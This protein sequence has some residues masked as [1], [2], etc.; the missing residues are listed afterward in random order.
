MARMVLRK[1]KKK[2]GIV[3]RIF[4]SLVIMGLCAAALTA[5]VNVYM[6]LRT[7]NKILTLQD[8]SN[9]DTD[10]VMVLGAGLTPAGEPSGMLADRLKVGI[11]LYQAEAA[12]KLLMSGDHGQT[13]YDEV[14]TMKTYA[15]ERGVPSS[16]VFM[17]H[18]GFS[19]YESL[20]RARDI[21]RVKKLVIVTQRYHLYRAIYNAERMGLEA[22]GVPS[23]LQRYGRQPYFSFREYLARV[24]DFIW[25]VFQPRPTY[26]G[27]AIPIWENGDA[28]ND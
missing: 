8:A 13:T 28:T 16:D 27:E 24:K 19:T 25:G 20:Y 7:R 26:L 4:R 2:R 11:D 3:F 15:I 9:L 6:I 1:T 17:D 12:P 10:C 18:A 14:N 23:N 21:F 5:A 22:Y